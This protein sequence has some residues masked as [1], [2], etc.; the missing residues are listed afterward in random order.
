MSPFPPERTAAKMGAVAKKTTRGKLVRTTLHNF[1]V[2]GSASAKKWQPRVSDA[3]SLK[4]TNVEREKTNIMLS[5]C[6]EN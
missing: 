2:D 6:N 3:C 5:I 4:Y 1:I